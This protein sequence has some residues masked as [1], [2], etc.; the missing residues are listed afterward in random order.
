M[1]SS[2][3][4]FISSATNQHGVHSPFVYDLITRCL[5]VDSPKKEIFRVKKTYKQLLK[6]N[7]R[8][9]V[10]DFGAGS[11]IFS[12]PSR[13]INRMVK[14]SAINIKYHL[15]LNRLIAY[16]NIK[17]V[18]E[19]GTHVGLG[20]LAMAKNNN[21]SIDTIEGCENTAEFS[22]DL[23][24]KEEVSHMINNHIGNLDTILEDVIKDKQ[25]DLIY[26]DGNHQ[27]KA[28]LDYFNQCLKT[29]H[30]NTVIILDDIHWSKE[31]DC[32]WEVI[33][34][35]NEVKVTIDL[36]QWGMVFFR[37]EQVKEHF[38]IRF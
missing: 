34:N 37:R 17:T 4:K 31:M 27:K 6:N 19:L 16:L 32:A 12:S 11:R 15:F 35:K 26:I 28:T 7:S 38:K 20:T 21:I 5:Y 13:K 1:L 30:N 18:L 2:Y 25:Y 8:I 23:F 9:V 33:K 10:N 14:Y 22:K 3:F 29:V 24:K 36:F